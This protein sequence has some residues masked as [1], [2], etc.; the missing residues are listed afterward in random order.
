ML[1]TH[2]SVSPLRASKVSQSNPNRLSTTPALHIHVLTVDR[3]RIL[4]THY[5]LLERDAFSTVDVCLTGHG[6]L[7][8]VKP[9]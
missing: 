9:Q 6:V 7:V 5:I 2:R 4:A 8:D 1:Q 3:I